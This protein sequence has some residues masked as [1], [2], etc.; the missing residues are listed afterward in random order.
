MFC[1]RRPA[2]IFALFSAFFIRAQK[3]PVARFSFDGKSHL[4]SITQD[5]A[6]F[7]NVGFVTDRFGNE[8]NAVYLFGNEY[9]YVNLGNDEALKPRAGAISFWMMLENNVW[10]GIGYQAN[11]L[12]LAKCSTNDDYFEAYS[13]QYSLKNNVLGVNCSRDSLRQVV[14]PALM[15]SQLMEWHHLVLTFDD[16]FIAFYL[17]GELQGRQVKNF[18]TRYQPGDSVLLGVTANKKNNRFFQGRIDD[19]EFYDRVLDSEEVQA[20]YH[21]PN[22]NRFTVMAVAVLKVLGILALLVLVYFFS[23]WQQNTARKKE[24]EQLELT[25]RLLETELRVNRGLMNPHFIYNS[26][27]SAQSFILNHEIDRANNYLVKFSRLL[28]KILEGN[29]SDVIALESEIDLLRSFVE[30][31][32]LK[33]DEPVHCTI[34]TEKD[35]AVSEIFIPVMMLQ[36]FV[37]NAIWHGLKNKPAPRQISVSFVLKP[38]NYLECVIEDNGIGRK[39]SSMAGG[40]ASSSLAIV[41]IKTR[42]D[43]LN[44]IHNKA[45]ELQIVD[46]PGGTGTI[47]RLLLPVMEKIHKEWI[48]APA[49]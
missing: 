22:P 29:M 20:L 41:F 21:A 34:N 28:R 14:L 46:K 35:L 23:R 47:I 32:N 33:F 15:P 39:A 6:K 30:I 5:T 2:I 27:Y 12:I 17:D 19:L 4:N 8:N 44:K 36:P 37:E 49:G 40:S 3:G 9:S 16:H 42:I 24:R 18:E 25:N 26:L 38:G 10:T 7:V 45:C 13:I 11:P 43:L 48:K 1:C 31:E